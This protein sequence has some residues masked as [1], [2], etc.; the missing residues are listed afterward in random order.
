M[1]SLRFAETEVMHTHRCMKN[2]SALNEAELPVSLLSGTGYL[3]SPRD[4]KALRG[5]LP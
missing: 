1:G 2:N 3:Q 5:R 4:D